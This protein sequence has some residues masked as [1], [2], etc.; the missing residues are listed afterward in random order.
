M[1]IV[2]GTH[3][4]TPG[5]YTRTE[6][7]AQTLALLTESRY[8]R[9]IASLADELDLTWHTV[10]DAVDW[11]ER[12]RRVEKRWRRVRDGYSYAYSVRAAA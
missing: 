12:G 4:T 3:D 2:S 8:P 10:K 9:T 6:T 11:L 5:P 7:A 1:T